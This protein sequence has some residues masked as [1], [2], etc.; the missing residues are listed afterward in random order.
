MS[1]SRL[2][3]GVEVV[4]VPGRGLA[5]RTTEGEFLGIRTRDA[6]QGTL[7]SLLSGAAAVPADGELN[8]VVR[9]FEEAGYLTG[10]PQHP[11]W[12]AA[13]RGVR[14]LG[15]P[16]LTGPLAAHL[17]A[18]GAEPRTTS[19]AT[20]P[21]APPVKIEELLDENPAAVVWCLDGPVPDGLWDAADRL[22][23]HGVAWLRCHR[24]GWQAYVEPLA[25]APGDVTAAHVRARRLAA[26]PAHRELAA[27]WSGPRTSGPPVRLTVPAAVLLA[28]LLAD[29]LSRWATGTPD[30]AGLPARRRLRCVD[31][32]TLTVTER[33]VLPVPDV[34][35]MP[36]KDG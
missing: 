19:P 33:P 28:A 23:G 10:E 1:R 25:A 21:D 14:L 3:P 2:V 8:H 18:L 9:A 4:A 31:L 29:D 17:A 27:Y 13:R 35:P 6:D 20:G 5:L 32:R 22:P 15:E 26:T 11:K 34:A 7:L 24:E 30:A 12:P 16:A 36:K